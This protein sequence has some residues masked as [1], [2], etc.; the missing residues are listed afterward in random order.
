[1]ENVE[2][3][4]KTRYLGDDTKNFAICELSLEFIV[5]LKHDVYRRER[6]EHRDN[7]NSDHRSSG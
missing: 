5:M 4:W 3:V 7:P 6:L 1:M 2:S